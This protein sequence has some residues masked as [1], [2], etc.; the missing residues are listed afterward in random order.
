MAREDPGGMLLFVQRLVETQ[1]QQGE[2]DSQL[3]Q[4][5]ATSR[6]E[7]AFAALLRRHGRLVWGVCR[8]VLRHEHDA[9]DAFQAT[10]LVLARR[11]AAVHKS[12]SLASFL[13]GVA[14]RI[15]VRAKQLAARRQGRESL[16]A[17]PENAMPESELAWRELQALL[18][19]ELA[20][21]PEKYRA[22]FLLCCLEGRSR[23]E[24]AAA[25]S[26]PQGTVSTR[27]AEARRLL[28][29]RL[30]RRGVSLPAVLTAGVL[31]SDP[32]SAAVPAELVRT[33]MAMASEQMG[34]ILSP[35]VCALVKSAL[36]RVSA[37][38]LLLSLTLVLTATVLSVAGFRPAAAEP[39]PEEPRKPVA[40]RQAPVPPQR[41]D[42]FGDLLPPDAVTRLGTNRFWCGGGHQVAWTPDG[43]KI[44]AA[45][46][47]DATVFD[48]SSGKQL[49]LIRPADPD[50]G[51]NSLSVSPDG[52]SLAL[53]T[54]SGTNKQG[55]ILIWDLATGQLLCECQT[56]GRQ[57]YLNVLFS[58]DGK[59]LASHAFPS[60]SIYLWDPATGKE[61]RRWRLASEPVGCFAFSA[62]SGTLIVG[63]QRSIRFL[64]NRTGKEVQ[65]IEDHAGFCVFHCHLSRDGKVLASQALTAEPKVGDTYR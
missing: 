9:E 64:D 56:T 47:T 6:D 54:D 28:Q 49:R 1:T 25:L 38:T 61:I 14:Y 30:A 52:K 39:G 15:A 43:S 35:A 7:K 37:G 36:P 12:E 59:S 51:I 16:A 18:D 17:A 2:N 22:P 33:T 5:F 21:L 32:A 27:I 46:W 20:R 10:F 13:H 57:Q 3:L 4:R 19:E 40:N 63:D 44:V 24:A 53:G 26:L 58:P 31:W 29:E 23:K 45:T 60:K 50:R 8:H 62:D 65:R 42:A 34:R 55:G 11:A 41:L 48:A